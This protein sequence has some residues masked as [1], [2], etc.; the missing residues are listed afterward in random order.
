MASCCRN[1][2]KLASAMHNSVHCLPHDIYVWQY[3]IVLIDDV[4]QYSIFNIQYS[5]SLCETI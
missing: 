4:G 5:N 2:D 1:I 3:I